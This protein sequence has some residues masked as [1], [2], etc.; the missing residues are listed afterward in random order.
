M[1]ALPTG[2]RMNDEGR[3]V[4]LR[5][6]SLDH[7]PRVA[8]PVSVDAHGPRSL[9]LAGRC[10]DGTVL[11]SLSTSEYGRWARERIDARANR[12]PSRWR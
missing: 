4:R 1:R 10:A 5:V 7:S 9:A 12:S 3:Y 11:D 6:E 8:P 2:E